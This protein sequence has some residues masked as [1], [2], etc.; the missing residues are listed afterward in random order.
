MPGSVGQYTQGWLGFQGHKSAVGTWTRVNSSTNLGMATIYNSSAAQNDEIVW[1]V[2]LDV[3]TWKIAYIT[4]KDVNQ[5]IATFLL[6][7]VSVGTVDT[8]AA[9]TQTNTYNEVTSISVTTAKVYSFTMK[10]ATKNASSSGYILGCQ[11]L[12]L[13][14]TAGS[15]STPSSGTDTPG[16]TWSFLPWMGVKSAVGA[17]GRFQGSGLLGGGF[18]YSGDQLNDSQSWDIWL[19]AGTYKY[20]HIYRRNTGNGINSVQLDGSTV[21]TIDEYG[22]LAD[23]VVAELT[24][25]VVATA[26]VKTFTLLMASKNASST[27]YAGAPNSV[28][29]IR[30]GA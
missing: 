26:G 7:G 20:V 21:G 23:N 16:Y 2:W 8:Y 14:R 1:D 24:G 29:W 10:A 30:T 19:D 11:S 27:G 12:A 15:G 17:N 25:I 22:A 28:A 5:G 18:G 13:I 3:G 4:Q 6:D 9:A